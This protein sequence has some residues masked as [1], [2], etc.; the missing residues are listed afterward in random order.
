MWHFHYAKVFPRLFTQTV[1]VELQTR[2]GCLS[3]VPQHPSSGR[4][5]PDREDGVHEQ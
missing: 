3:T 5:L 4:I 1:S 2:H